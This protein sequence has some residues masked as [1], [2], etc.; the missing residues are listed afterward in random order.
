M[1]C[2]DKVQWGDWRKGTLK[3]S[4]L[5]PRDGLKTAHTTSSENE[6]SGADEISRKVKLKDLA[7]ILKDTRS[8]FAHLIGG[9][10]MEDYQRLRSI[11]LRAIKIGGTRLKRGDHLKG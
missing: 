6:E 5:P 3:K 9:L 2:N 1:V 10:D 8:A 7:D 4:C 11:A